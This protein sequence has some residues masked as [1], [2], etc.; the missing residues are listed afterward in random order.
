[1]FSHLFNVC[2]GEESLSELVCQQGLVQLT[3]ESL[4]NIGNIVLTEQAIIP[5][6]GKLFE[7]D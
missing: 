4:E 6:H 2:C 7:L 5:R 3:D 1:M